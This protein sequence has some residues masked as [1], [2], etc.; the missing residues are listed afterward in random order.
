MWSCESIKGHQRKTTL[1]LRRLCQV[2]L[3]K[4]SVTS[5][6]TI[7]IKNVSAIVKPKA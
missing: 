7:D 5:L 3:N 4:F 2:L 6:G 1:K